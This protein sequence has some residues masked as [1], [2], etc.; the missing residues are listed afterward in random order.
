[1]KPFRFPLQAV[2]TVRVSQEQKALEAFS[3]AQ[4]QVEQIATRKRG[5]LSEIEG[6]YNQRRER[7]SRVASSEEIQV[8]QQGLRALHEALRRCQVELQAAEAILADKSKALLEARQKREVIEKLHDKQR[9]SHLAEASKAEQRTS[10]EFAT[11]KS[12]GNL[13]MRWR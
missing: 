3:R 6:V 7:L 13:A 5:I 11:L 2:R 12:I 9:A 1:M 10:D 4:A 8:M